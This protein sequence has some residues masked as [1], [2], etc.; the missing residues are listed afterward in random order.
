MTRC[1]LDKSW[2]LTHTITILVVG[3]TT[4]RRNPAKTVIPTHPP[5]PS[6]YSPHQ[7]ALH[8][9]HPLGLRG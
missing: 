3:K 5:S 8:Q 4:F 6:S 2:L 7:M 9:Y 1:S